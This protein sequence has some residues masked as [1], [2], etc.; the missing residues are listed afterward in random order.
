MWLPDGWRRIFGQ[1]CSWTWFDLT[2]KEG[3][4]TAT[5]YKPIYIGQHLLFGLDFHTLEMSV[6]VWT[7][8]V[9]SQQ[10]ILGLE[11]AA[12]T[13]MAWITSFLLTGLVPPSSLLKV[14]SS[15]SSVG[16]GFLTSA[17]HRNRLLGRFPRRIVQGSSNSKLDAQCG[18][19]M[20]PPRPHCRFALPPPQST[21][22][23]FVS[24]QH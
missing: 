20:D 13:A 11:S 22:H 1:G 3:A 9:F 17:S 23:A 14:V 16:L 10:N 21:P 4:I 18:L 2:K 24:P 19:G 15:L 12:E 6:M 7:T 8:P 5:G